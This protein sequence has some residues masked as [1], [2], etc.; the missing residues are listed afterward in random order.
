MPWEGAHHV[1]FMR[2]AGT[3]T[4]RSTEREI[5]CLTNLM[6][7]KSTED[8]YNI[9]PALFGKKR[10]NPIRPATVHHSMNNEYA[11]ARATGC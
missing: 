3:G 7:T 10:Q 6:A 11:C 1:P 9:G 4:R 2:W 8:S 5:I